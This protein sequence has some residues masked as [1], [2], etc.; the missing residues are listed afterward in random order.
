[1]I[2]QD[3]SWFTYFNHKNFFDEFL[4]QIVNLPKEDDYSSQLFAKLALF[5]FMLMQISDIRV[6]RANFPQER[7]ARSPI[8]LGLIYITLTLR[9]LPGLQ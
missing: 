9:F 1:M 6:P 8:N 4:Q 7:Y 5:R 3:V 2:R